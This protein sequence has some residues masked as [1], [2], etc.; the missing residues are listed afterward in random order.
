MIEQIDVD[1]SGTINYQGTL[2]F[3]ISFYGNLEFLMAAVEKRKLVSSERL[4]KVFKMFDQDDNGYIEADDLQIMFGGE[5][6]DKKL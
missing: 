3:Y 1:H 2:H 4:N 6:H 5:I